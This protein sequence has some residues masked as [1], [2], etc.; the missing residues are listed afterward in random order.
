M[1]DTQEPQPHPLPSQQFCGA[2]S[3]KNTWKREFFTD[4]RQQQVHAF[5]EMGF[6]QPICLVSFH[7]VIPA[8]GANDEGKLQKT[9]EHLQHF[10]NDLKNTIHMYVGYTGVSQNF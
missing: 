1:I 4:A 10:G 6:G 3:V 7:H 5:F 2:F 8:V 9:E